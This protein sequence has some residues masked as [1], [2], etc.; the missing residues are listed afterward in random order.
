MGME[1][2]AEG[3]REF[4]LAELAKYDGNNGSRAYIVFEGT[5]YDVSDSPLWRNGLHLRK[6]Q[7]GADLTEQ[8]ASAPH[9]GEVLTSER[10][11]Q[12]GVLRRDQR[13]WGLPPLLRA[14]FTRFPTLRRHPHPISVHFPSAYLIAGALFTLL[15]LASPGLF[16]F[17]SEKAAYAM[18]I[19]G[20]L[21]TIAAVGTGVLTLGVNYRFKTPPLVKAKIAI[22]VLTVIVEAACLAL[23][24]GGPLPFAGLGVLYYGQM[25]L[26][27][28]L[29]IALGYSGGQMVF[30]TRAR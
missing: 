24:A 19:L 10:I 29:V 26:L 13:G 2:R 16:G 23:R 15:H 6:H 5:V 18:L 9:W 14:L 4:T 28:I 7:A 3:A 20:S 1:P 27:A 17:D 11:R 25:L 30:P 21:S 8:L 22:S 12:V